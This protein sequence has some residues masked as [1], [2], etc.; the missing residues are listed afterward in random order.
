MYRPQELSK[1]THKPTPKNKNLKSNIDG[2]LKHRSSPHEF[3]ETDHGN[4]LRLDNRNYTRLG[5]E[6][7]AG[8][9]SVKKCA[10][11]KVLLLHRHR[12]LVWRLLR[13]ALSA[14]GWVVTRTHANALCET[15]FWL[16][17]QIAFALVV[18]RVS[19]INAFPLLSADHIVRR[20]AIGP[21]TPSPCLLRHPLKRK[22]Q[23][24]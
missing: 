23:D 12:A 24:R 13:D 2:G 15:H 8:I 18:G 9:Q 17:H 11:R 22:K 3:N 21:P 6:G 5:R 7:F 4:N 19:R 14:S 10:R 1:I 16:E 20:V